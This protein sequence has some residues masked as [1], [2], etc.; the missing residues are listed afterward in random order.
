MRHL[1]KKALSSVRR[2]HEIPE[3]DLARVD[4]G[5]NTVISSKS[6]VKVEQERGKCIVFVARPEIRARSDRSHLQQ[7]IILTQLVKLQTQPK[8]P[9]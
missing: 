1:H 2:R 4:L 8:P 7:F 6:R 5:T 3:T 9:L